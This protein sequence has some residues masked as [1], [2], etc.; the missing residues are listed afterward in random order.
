MA[1]V[2]NNQQEDDRNDRILSGIRKVQEICYC[3][4]VLM[5]GVSGRLNF[6]LREPIPSLFMRDRPGNL[7]HVQGSANRWIALYI[8]PAREWSSACQE[9][10]GYS[11]WHV[12]GYIFRKWW[13]GH[14]TPL[15]F[16]RF[17]VKCIG[18]QGLSGDRDEDHCAILQF[19]ESLRRQLEL[20][21]ESRIVLRKAIFVSSRR[22]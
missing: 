12:L 21:L 16:E 17:P 6:N 4:K 8:E 20:A 2:L 9:R 5:H 3:R 11:P 18:L 10:W 22:S 13:K 14:L 19:H 7:D 1:T 15:D